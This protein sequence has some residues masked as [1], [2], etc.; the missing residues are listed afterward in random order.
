MVVVSNEVFTSMLC[1]EALWSEVKGSNLKNLNQ[2]A[3]LFLD[4]N[5]PNIRKC[6]EAK[7][8]KMSFNFTSSKDKDYP[9]NLKYSYISNFYYQGNLS[10]ANN[11]N[12]VAIVGSRN[13]SSKGISICKKVTRDFVDNNFT[14]ISGL[15]EGTDT[16][17]MKET[18]DCGSNNLIGVIGTPLG[19]F[20]PRFNKPLQEYIAKNCLLISHIPFYKSTIQTFSSKSAYFPERNAVMANLA[21]L[22]VIIE[23]KEKSGTLTHARHCLEA[24]KPLFIMDNNKGNWVD[25]LVDKGAIVVSDVDKILEFLNE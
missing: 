17:A 9:L 21:D 19:E 14:I 10:L 5:N 1:Y 8:A 15:A 18:I 3:S 25:N 20:Y 24:N 4:I 12:K 7:L 2:G 16:T 13:I 23:A 22:S 11:K 6:I